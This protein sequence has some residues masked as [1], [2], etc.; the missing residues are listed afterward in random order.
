MVNGPIIETMNC[1]NCGTRIDLDQQ[2]CRSCGTELTA[3]AP[4]HFNIQA[5]GIAALM[6]IFGGMLIAMGGKLWAV[7]WIVFLGVAITFGGMFGIAAFGLMRQA[8]PRKRPR[9]FPVPAP[10]ELLRADTTRKLRP[11]DESDFMP[12]VVDDTTDLLKTP[13]VRE[14][15][16]KD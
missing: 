13:A 5:W 9:P 2:Y 7:K 1:P 14:T 12:S 16:S 6:L 4:R 11:I 10:D 8:R 15:L 3:E